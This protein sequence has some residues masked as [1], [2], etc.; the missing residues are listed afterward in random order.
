MNDAAA[1]QLGMRRR[2]A[3]DLPQKLTNVA[4]GIELLRAGCAAVAE[5]KI[6]GSGPAN[7]FF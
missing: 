6:F 2:A 5:E 3:G 4:N 1:A 7:R